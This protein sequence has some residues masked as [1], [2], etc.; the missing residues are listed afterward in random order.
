MK[1]LVIVS[2]VAINIIFNYRVYWHQLITDLSKTGA[3]YGE[4][5]T[6]EWALE[7][8]Y[9]SLISGHNPFGTSTAILYPFG[10]NFSML[11]LGNGLFF[12]LLRPFLSTHQTIYTLV[13]VSLI[14]AN[15][16]MYLLLRKLSFNK[17]ISFI[18]G[19]AYGI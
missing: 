12:P 4:V 6:Y 15:I 7:K 3:V 19:A 11:D 17:A 14:I 16:G 18:V 13:T 1:L 9:Q 5:Q 10:L 8:F 2:Y